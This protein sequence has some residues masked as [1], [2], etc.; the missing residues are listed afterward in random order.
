MDDLLKITARRVEA[1]CSKC[2][3]RYQEGG[4]RCLSANPT[5][6]NNNAILVQMLAPRPTMHFLHLSSSVEMLLSV[7]AVFT[8][9]AAV[10]VDH[11]SVFTQ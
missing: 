4:V 8:V 9:L 7:V 11:I 10:V 3:I 5:E 6:A 1:N 2:V